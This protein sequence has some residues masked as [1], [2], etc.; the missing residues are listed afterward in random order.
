MGA[1]LSEK[2]WP[3][4]VTVIDIR[5]VEDVWQ[6]VVCKLSMHPLGVEMRVCGAVKKCGGMR[7]GWVFCFAVKGGFGAVAR[8]VFYS[9][10][11][12]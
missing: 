8:V 10:Y 4:A 7:W 9:Q 6:K 11:N 5:L 2:R 12:C 3:V 1:A